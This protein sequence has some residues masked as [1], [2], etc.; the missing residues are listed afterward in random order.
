[1]IRKSVLFARFS[2]CL[3][4][5][6]LA[7]AHA[8]TVLPTARPERVGMSSERLARMSQVMQGYIDRGELAGTVTLVARHGRI[9]HFEARGYRY[10]EEKLPMT[11]DT[12]F[13]IAS[14]TK[15]IAS[16]ALMMLWEEGHFALDDP[17][18]K[19]MPEFANPLVA[20][21]APADE[22]VPEPYKTVPAARP[23]TIR[24]I[25]T[26][27]AGLAN[28]YRGY[29]REALREASQ[30]GEP[31][32][33]V[34]ES[35]LKTKDVPLN[36]HPGD[37]WE[38]GPA[39]NFVGVIVEK[40]SGMTLDE[41]FRVRIFEPLGMTDTHFNIPQ[42]K[43]ARLSAMYRPDENGKFVLAA[44]PEYREPNTFFSGAGGLSSTAADY[45]RFC[46]MILNGGELDGVR[47]LSPK[48]IDL[49]ITNHIGDLHV[50]LKGPG[51]GFGLG[52]S[53]LLDPGK[54]SEAL[55]PGSFGWGGAFNTY[56]W[57]DPVE[58][59]IGI[60]MSQMRPYTHL[61]VRTDLSTIAT[62]AI[63]QSNRHTN[64]NVL[65]YSAIRPEP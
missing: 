42:H 35:L 14:M 55:S 29:T 43:V 22:R 21:K 51:Y 62:Q 65:G 16:V 6:G 26:H 27:T 30:Q 49:M 64:P 34:E 23:I 63:L 33:T 2:G 7:A 58:D 8:G 46:Q 31:A 61:N 39:T 40:I 32:K 5:V 50:W 10:A 52:F 13:R 38:Y 59:M 15:P 36:F 48:T 37:E 20:V 24:H 17:I 44:A 11:E 28:T 57:I 60:F 47:I 53:V 18:S 19:W 41:F 25:L 9:V 56:F 1:M 3:A 4:V 45:W 12:I 54:A